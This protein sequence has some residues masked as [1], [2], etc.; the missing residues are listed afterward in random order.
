SLSLGEPSGVSRRVDSTVIGPGTFTIIAGPCSVA[1]EDMILRTADYLM[2]QG[3]R[4]MRAGAFKP[5]TSPYSFQRL[6]LAG[7]DILKKARAKT[8]IGIVTEL[9]D[10]D[11]ADAVEDAADIMQIVK[12]DMRNF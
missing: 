8:G 7:L 6:G 1:N 3:V 4:L 5:R 12:R 9:M 10:T 11:N 2:A